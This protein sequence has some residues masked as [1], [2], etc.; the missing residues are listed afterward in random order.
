MTYSTYSSEPKVYHLDKLTFK[1]KGY[2]KLYEC[3]KHRKYC[4]QQL[5]QGSTIE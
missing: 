4:D 1:G 2:N 3:D 5:H